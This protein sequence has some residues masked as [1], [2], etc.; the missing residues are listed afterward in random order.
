MATRQT[1]GKSTKRATAATARKPAPGSASSQ[2]T[3]AGRAASRNATKPAR[4][5][6]AS[7]PA[8]PARSGGEAVAAEGSSLVRETVGRQSADWPG[9]L[10]PAGGRVSVTA[11]VVS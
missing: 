10:V 6:A 1:A 9:G 2:A 3:S 11:L 7:S 5:A 4:G 8:K